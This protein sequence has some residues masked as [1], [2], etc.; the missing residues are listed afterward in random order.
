MVE[1]KLNQRG[2]ELIDN[3]AK[4]SAKLAKMEAELKVESE[5]KNK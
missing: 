1:K 4:T 3:L 5:I 2:Q